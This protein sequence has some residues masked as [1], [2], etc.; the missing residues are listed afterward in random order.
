MWMLFVLLALAGD[1]LAP[2]PSL[3]VGDSALLF[4]LPAVNEDVSMRLMARTSVS[5]GDLTGGDLATTDN[6]GFAAKAVV[7]CFIDGSTSAPQLA[8]LNRLQKKYGNRG[9]RMVAIVS[10]SID[11]ATLSEWITT[12]K[13]DIPVL[14][15]QYKIVA[16]RYG[17]KTLPLTFVVDAHGR[18]DAIGIAKDDLEI[19]LDNILFDLMAQ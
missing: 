6:P 15:D 7:L 9:V 14:H 8:M 12:Q 10:D 1:T 5:L 16:S 13:L 17:V 11:I 3:K 4:S 19:S 18:V 2:A